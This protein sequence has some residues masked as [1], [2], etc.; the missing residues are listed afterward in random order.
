MQLSEKVI[1]FDGSCNLCNKSVQ[2]ILK[3]DTNKTF[4]FASL[5]SAYGQSILKK[6][7]LPATEFKTFIL[8]QDGNIY[9]RSDGALKVFIQLKGYLWLKIF[10]I[11][12]TF[13]R[14]FFYDRIANN[15]YRW[16]GKSNECLITSSELQNRFLS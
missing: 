15:R 14:D 4:L 3:K 16:F 9:L 12:P 11:I 5:Q 8:Y 6:F 7:K 1:L 10:Y 2:F 13:V